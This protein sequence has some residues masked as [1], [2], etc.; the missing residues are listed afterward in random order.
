MICILDILVVFPNTFLTIVRA[1]IVDFSPIIGVIIEAFS[2]H[3]FS[4]TISV[5]FLDFKDLHNDN[6]EYNSEFLK[7]FSNGRAF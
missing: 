4:T 6:G 7:I 1:L 2:T 3:I 5:I